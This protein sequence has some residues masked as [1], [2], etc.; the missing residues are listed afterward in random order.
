[1]LLGSANI[2]KTDYYGNR[3]ILS[4]VKEGEIFGEAFAC[5]GVDSM[6]VTVTANELSEVMLIDSNHI[7]HTCSNNCAFHRRLI[8]NLMRSLATKNILFHR[9]LEVT[10]KR[11]TRE[12]L[13]CYL[14]QCERKAGS[15]SFRI[16]F[17]C[18]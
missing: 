2:N 14:A 3:S 9:R 7:L 11:T 17:D 4:N 5:A 13:L 10:S 15:P 18:R 16:P 6:P 1:M 12:K 8:F